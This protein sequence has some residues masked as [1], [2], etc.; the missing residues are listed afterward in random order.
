VSV[1]DYVTRAER[2]GAS[3][4]LIA[5]YDLEGVCFER[6]GLGAAGAATA[7][8]HLFGPAGAGAT[9]VTDML[10]RTFAHIARDDA[11]PDSP[12]PLVFV[13]VPF[14][15]SRAGTVVLPARTIRRDREGETWQL[16]ILPLEHDLEAWTPPERFVGRAAPHEA[17]SD[18]QLRPVPPPDAYRLAVAEAT[19]RIHEGELRKVVLAR[20]I[21]VAAGRR[22]DPALLLWRLRAVDPDCYAFAFPV[23]D[24][25]PRT[26]VGASPELLVSRRGL[27]VRSEPL[28]GSA[29]RSGDPGEDRASGE[30]LLASAKDREEHA[31]VVEAIEET[32]SPLCEKLERDPEPL[33]LATANVWHLATRFRGRL[34]RPAPDALSLAMA[35]HPTPAVCGAPR[36]VAKRLIRELE[37][38]DRDGYAGPVGWVDAEGDGEFALALR[39]AELRDDEAR[40]FAG[41]GIVADS[42][43]SLELDETERKF[44][45]LLDALRWS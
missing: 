17:F 37:P 4:D 15:S 3:F 27:E 12:S 8:R 40:L 9:H 43:P 10:E 25:R 2:R 41:A 26:L 31:I 34:R 39:C 30:R 35:L 1:P 24:Q 36:S 22:L 5:A 7:F 6:N 38:F 32:L 42:D 16:T 13:S 28:A 21:D 33:L 23:G 29:P 18:M 45:A 14:D 44:R 20:T 11:E 19:R